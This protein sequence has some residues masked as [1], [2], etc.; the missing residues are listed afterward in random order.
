M[1]G[2]FMRISSFGLSLLLLST[3]GA[4][5]FGRVDVQNFPDKTVYEVTVEGVDF[6][7]VEIEGKPFS[8]ASFKGVTGYEGVKAELGKPEVPVVRFLHRWRRADSG[9]GRRPLDASASK[10]DK[11]DPGRPSRRPQRHRAQKTGWSSTRNFTRPA[12][13]VSPA[14]SRSARSDRF[15]GRDAD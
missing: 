14:L 3:L 10:S 5:G 11:P 4:K 8:Q 7:P 2:F 13:S 9:R 15:A 12:V 6:T 1:R